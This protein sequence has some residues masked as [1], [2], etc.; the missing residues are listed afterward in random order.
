MAELRPDSRRWIESFPASSRPPWL[1][2]FPP[3][4]EDHRSHCASATPLQLCCCVEVTALRKQGAHEIEID[5]AV[6]GLCQRSVDGLDGAVVGRGLSELGRIEYRLPRGRRLLA[7]SL[8][9]LQTKASVRSAHYLGPQ[10]EKNASDLLA[11]C[12]VVVPGS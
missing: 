12:F 1:A 5:D 3:E 8:D 4:A 10:P 6:W 2:S 11:G 7:E 9:R